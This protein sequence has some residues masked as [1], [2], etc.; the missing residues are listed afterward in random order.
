MWP[1]FLFVGPKK[2]KKKFRLRR[3]L[4]PLYPCK[5]LKKL[6]KIACSA[7]YTHFTLVNCPNNSKFFACGAL[8]LMWRLFL[9]LVGMWPCFFPMSSNSENMWHSFLSLGSDSEITQKC[10]VAFIKGGGFIFNSLVVYFNYF[11]WNHRKCLG[12]P[13]TDVGSPNDHDFWAAPI[14][15][16]SG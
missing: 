8:L 3:A 13:K 7:L 4:H 10:H 1:L 5:L 15:W 14:F 9:L 12:A 11:F 16:I 2:A 6:K